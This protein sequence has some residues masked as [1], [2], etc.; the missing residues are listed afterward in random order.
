MEVGE[1]GEKRGRERAGNGVGLEEKGAKVGK[2]GEGGDGERAGEG[3]RAEAE[4]G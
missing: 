1:V 2:G 3:V 4:L